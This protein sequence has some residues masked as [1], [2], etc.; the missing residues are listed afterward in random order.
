MR[1][2]HG[3]QSRSVRHIILLMMYNVND[4]MF[5]NFVQVNKKKEH[6]FKTNRTQNIKTNHSKVVLMKST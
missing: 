2:F 5:D 6:V 4:I 3:H 1:L